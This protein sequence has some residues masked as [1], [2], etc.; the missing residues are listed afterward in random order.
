[1]LEFQV[2]RSTSIVLKPL[3]KTE[4]ITFVANFLSLFMIFWKEKLDGARHIINTIVLNFAFLIRKIFFRILSLVFTRIIRRE[5][6]SLSSKPLRGGSSAECHQKF[7]S[8]TA[9]LVSIIPSHYS[10]YQTDAG[11]FM[12]IVDVGL[13]AALNG[14]NIYNG[15]LLKDKF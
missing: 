7:T 8:I 10:L 15:R 3:S 13:W 1:M 14:Y 11:V 5:F 6:S 12:W 4:V 2:V 9:G